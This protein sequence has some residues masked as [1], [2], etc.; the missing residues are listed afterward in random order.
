MSPKEV[1]ELLER[2]KAWVDETGDE[3]TRIPES[4]RIIHL[5]SQIAADATRY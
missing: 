2:V 3:I 1:I 5:A 4:I